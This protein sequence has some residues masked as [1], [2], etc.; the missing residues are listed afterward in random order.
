MVPPS[1]SITGVGQ[2]YP[3][4]PGP[5]GVERHDPEVID[6]IPVM[7][8]YPGNYNSVRLQALGSCRKT[9]TTARFIS[10][11]GDNNA[12]TRLIC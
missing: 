3:I 11:R 2:V 12:N 6:Q 4:I 10:D 9:T 8:F 5:Q 1:C 7:M